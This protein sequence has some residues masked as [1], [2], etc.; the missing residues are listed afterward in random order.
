MGGGSNPKAVPVYFV[1]IYLF[2][3]PN[4]AAYFTVYGR[5]EKGCKWTSLDFNVF[6][7]IENSSGRRRPALNFKILKYNKSFI[8]SEFKNTFFLF[9]N[10]DR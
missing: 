3:T 1:W 6:D 10:V 5:D 7:Q 2:W 8:I 9:F 4:E